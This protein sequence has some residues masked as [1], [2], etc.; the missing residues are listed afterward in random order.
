MTPQ[1][2][3]T[4]VDRSLT[5][6]AKG[7]TWCVDPSAEVVF[8]LAKGGFGEAMVF[9]REGRIA[10]KGRF[11]DDYNVLRQQVEELL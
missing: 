6:E 3:G 2:L 10:Y 9:D 4:L 7:L 5:A 8:A 1:E 11:P